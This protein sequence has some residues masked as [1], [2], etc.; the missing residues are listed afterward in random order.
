M[1]KEG[2]VWQEDK[3]SNRIMWREE[4]DTKDKDQHSNRMWMR[5]GIEGEQEQEWG[6]GWGWGLG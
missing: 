3:D 6:W 4:D 1:R 2:Q 5:W